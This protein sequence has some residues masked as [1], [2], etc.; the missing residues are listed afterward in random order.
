LKDKS[1]PTKFCTMEC[2]VGYRCDTSTGK[3]RCVKDTK[4]SPSPIDHPSCLTLTC[5]KNFHCEQ[6]GGKA[7]CVANDDG[8]AKCNKPGMDCVRGA[9][10]KA[11]CVKSKP[12]GDN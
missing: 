10:G 6:K 2:K 11:K 9:D 7:G 5:M 3:E 4:P 1:K 8:C 12:S